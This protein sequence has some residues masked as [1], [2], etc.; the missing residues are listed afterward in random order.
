MRLGQPNPLRFLAWMGIVACLLPASTSAGLDLVEVV[1]KIENSIVRID[2]DAASLGSGV[3]IDDR[4][5]VLTNFHVV[6]GASQVQITMRSGKLVAAQGFLAADPKYDLALLR[7][8]KFDDGTAIKFAD[9][10]PPIGEK[11]A[12]LGNPR[13]FSFST[14]EGIVSAIRTGKEIIEAIGQA[15]YSYLGYA[16]DATWI[17]TS[18]AISGGNSGGPLVNMNGELLALNTWSHTGGSNLN[19]AIALPDIHRIAD[20]HSD[21]SSPKKFT[22]LPKRS[23]REHSTTPGE[24]G[25]RPEFKLTLPSGRVFSFEIFTKGS[26]SSLGT[27]RDNTVSIK[28]PNGVL[29]AMAGQQ[30]GLLHGTT[31]A[32]WENGQPMVF[33]SYADGKRHGILLTWNE[34]GKP[35]LFGQYSHGKRHGFFCFFENGDFRLLTEQKNDQL[36]RVQ[37]MSDEVPLE[38]FDSRDEAEKNS[39][40]RDLLEAQDEFE[41]TLKT[42]EIAFRKQI[43]EFEN[44]KRRALAAALSPE[45][46]KQQHQRAMQSAAEQDAFNRDF[47]RR[48]LGGR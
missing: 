17:Q 36:Q 20:N 1:K 33:A 34:A 39:M 47:T 18:A 38:G 45:K 25:R 21:I 23:K 4:G 46:R 27:N 14:T 41:A 2:V 8:D 24:R 5:L 40:A 19:F 31:I 10:L 12:A 11:V 32:K 3:I 15:N 13:G 26:L 44:A 35:V 30:N 16:E 42:N 7:T 6:E 29:Y 48:A 9:K 43:K 37:L 28:H 22:E